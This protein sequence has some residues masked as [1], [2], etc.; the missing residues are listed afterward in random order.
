[1]TVPRGRSGQIPGVKVHWARSPAGRRDRRFRD[2]LPCTDVARTIVDLAGVVTDDDLCDLVDTAL[3]ERLTRPGA[4]EASAARAGRAPGRYGRRRLRE[5]LAV[6]TPGPVADSVA[7][8]R[9]ARRIQQWGFPPLERQVEIRDATGRFI[10]V[11][12][13]GLS[14]ERIYFEYDGKKGHCV[15]WW[16]RDD[17]RDAAIEATGGT[18]LRFNR[19]DLLPSSTRLRDEIRTLLDRRPGLSA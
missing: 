3:C 17:R 14:H 12:D 15:R 5:A 16:G 10:A 7:E 19:H 2:G 13:L 18:V 1:M 9:L 4:I 11:A 8:M 6:W